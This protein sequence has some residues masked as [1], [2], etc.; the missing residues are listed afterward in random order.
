MNGAETTAMM[1]SIQ[2]G[3]GRPIRK[4]EIESFSWTMHQFGQK[5]PAATYVHSLQLWDQAAVT[6][7]ELFQKFDLF[8]SP[9][10]AFSAPKL[11][12]ICKVSTFVNE[13]RKQQN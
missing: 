13:W 8:L 6:M 5:I 10:T 7:E 12:K 4:E 3:L 2:Q 9:T 1:N 11:T